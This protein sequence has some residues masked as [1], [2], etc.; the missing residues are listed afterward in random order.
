MIFPAVWKQYNKMAVLHF[1]LVNSSLYIL[2]S[3]A[4]E[5]DSVML[6]SVYIRHIPPTPPTELQNY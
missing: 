5:Q 6:H 3:M 4:M 2:F 1:F